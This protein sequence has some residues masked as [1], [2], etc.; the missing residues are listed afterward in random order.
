VRGRVHKGAR[1]AG[2]GDNRARGGRGKVCLLWVEP[3]QIV[4]RWHCEGSVQQRAD[5]LL[6]AAAQKI[7]TF[8]R[9]R[10]ERA[11]E[12][13]PTSSEAYPPH[14]KNLSHAGAAAGSV[15]QSTCPDALLQLPPREFFEWITCYHSSRGVSLS[16]RR[17]PQMSAE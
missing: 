1:L 8:W 12:Y 11:A 7:V 17:V 13:V 2:A 5:R 6:P 14:R 4:T 16:F 9:C 15:Q 10:R 3:D